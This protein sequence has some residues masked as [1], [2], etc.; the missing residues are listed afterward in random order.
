[1]SLIFLTGEFNDVADRS[2]AECELFSIIEPMCA[3]ASA[4]APGQHSFY[5]ESDS[6]ECGESFSQASGT[7]K[8]LGCKTLA[9]RQLLDLP[10]AVAD[11]I[12]WS[13]GLTI[14]FRTAETCK[15]ELQTSRVDCEERLR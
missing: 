2:T 10:R 13:M 7:A 15:W 8:V 9:Q 4:F 5:I 12:Y 11:Y 14:R 3:A 6:G 1:M